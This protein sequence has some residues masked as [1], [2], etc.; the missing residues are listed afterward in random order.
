MS[1]LQCY[2]LV[3]IKTTANTNKKRRIAMKKRIMI[4]GI[5]SAATI[6]SIVAA[7]VYVGILPTLVSKNNSETN[8]EPP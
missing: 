3:K 2:N 8:T 7:I 5:V 1:L 6:I 4:L